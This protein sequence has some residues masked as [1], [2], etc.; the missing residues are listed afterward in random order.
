M[1]AVTT[2]R[3]FQ[4]KSIVEFMYH[5]A[6]HQTQLIDPPDCDKRLAEDVLTLRLDTV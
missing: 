3:L 5:T 4:S 2:D 6:L 1:P